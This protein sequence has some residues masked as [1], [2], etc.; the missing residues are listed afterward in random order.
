MIEVDYIGQRHELD[1]PED[2]AR[3]V[4]AYLQ[5]SWAFTDR[6]D[7]PA[8]MSPP[9]GVNAHVKGAGLLH[10]VR[11]A[12]IRDSVMSLE[13]SAG[14]ARINHL[15]SEESIRKSKHALVDAG[16]RMEHSIGA[17]GSLVVRSIV[18]AAF[19]VNE[20]ALE[21]LSPRSYKQWKNGMLTA[22]ELEY[23]SM[24]ELL[25]GF[26]RALV[27]I[28][29]LT[30]SEPEEWSRMIWM[31][32]RTAA[33]NY[34]QYRIV[35]LLDACGLSLPGGFVTMT[36]TSRARGGLPDSP[37]SER[38][39]D[40]IL[41]FAHV[42][43][44]HARVMVEHHYREPVLESLRQRMLELAR[45]RDLSGET[46]VE[47]VRDQLHGFILLHEAGHLDTDEY[48]A[49]TVSKNEGMRDILER[50]RCAMQIAAEANVIR[51]LLG[52][53]DELLS[54]TYLLASSH[55]PPDTI[56]IEDPR[57]LLECGHCIAGVHALLDGGNAETMMTLVRELVRKRQEHRDRTDKTFED[58]VSAQLSA[59]AVESAEM[60]RRR[61]GL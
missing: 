30:T 55:K 2:Y 52:E 35:Q 17:A 53:P 16:T 48:F 33:S 19:C 12:D 4:L 31:A 21:S 59:M 56:E 57:E 10:A 18:M 14:W 37:A 23:R 32:R 13:S 26:L 51:A 22:S 15:L 27:E 61:Y 46:L 8:A 3:A 39:Q 54:V 58:E 44:L 9:I 36:K 34:A 7:W 50:D 41:L 6:G 47:W 1:D 49:S 5:A 43:D 25:T 11:A 42:Q 45:L 38:W 24:Y 60:L 29:G 28:P 40:T 20:Q